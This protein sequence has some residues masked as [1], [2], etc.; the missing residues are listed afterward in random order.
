MIT[1]IITTSAR[2][3]RTKTGITVYITREPLVFRGSENVIN[4]VCGVLFHTCRL[5]LACYMYIPGMVTA[6]TIDFYLF[7]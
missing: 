3:N 2:S 7:K 4:P 6:A 5:T 1:M